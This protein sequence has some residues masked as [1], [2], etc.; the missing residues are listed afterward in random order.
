MVHMRDIIM[1]IFTWEFF[2]YGFKCLCIL[3]TVVIF[4]TWL[5]RYILDEDT[6]VIETTSYFDTEDDILPM[7]SICF[8][9]TF[10]NVDFQKMGFNFTGMEYEKY[11]RGDDFNPVMEQVDYEIVSTNISEF[12]ISYM[13]RYWNGTLVWDTIENLSW[14]PP[15][16]IAT[17]HGGDY[18]VKCFGL[19][20]IHQNVNFVAMLMR[21]EIFPSNIRPRNRGFNVFFHYPNQLLQ[22]YGT[23]MNQWKTED[24]ASTS[25]WMEFNVRRMEAFQH[26]YK[27]KKKNCVPQ[28]RN[29][30][31]IMME[32]HVKYVGCKTPYHPKSLDFPIC[33][34]M[35]DMLKANTS[36]VERLPPC[37]EIG[38]I[39]PELFD[40]VSKSSIKMQGKV[41][42]HFFAIRFGFYSKRFK[43][44]ITKEEVDFQSLIGYVGGYVGLI[45]GFAIAQIPEVIQ[46]TVTFLVKL[47]T[48]RQKRRNE[49]I[50]LN[51]NVDEIH[52]H[53][54]SQGRLSRV[55]EIQNNRFKKMHEL[56]EIRESISK[57]EEKLNSDYL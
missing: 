52:G 53:K 19:E 44:T 27:P 55:A 54:P 1:N 5:Q 40:A 24:I 18:I 25:Y 23:I 20:L 56:R 36:L 43:K 32:E 30:D 7:M 10:A 41:W 9:Q 15:Y 3:V 47:R 26:R 11:L 57:L 39:E 16:H 49:K 51:E 14:K 33:R 50:V 17:L 46:T 22:S 37:R 13:V 8:K 29:Y 6:S 21:R 34:T 48:D 28:W 38:S 45:M 12:L 2:N 31:Q 35:A 42:K 4:G